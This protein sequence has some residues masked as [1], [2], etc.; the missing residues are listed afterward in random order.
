MMEWLGFRYHVVFL[1]VIQVFLLPTTAS[2]RRLSFW[3]C[4]FCLVFVL[5]PSTAALVTL[6]ERADL[7][8][9]GCHA[10]GIS[11][12]TLSHRQC[13]VAQAHVWSLWHRRRVSSPGCWEV[14]DGKEVA[15]GR[16]T[17]TAR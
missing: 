1:E 13:P 10:H 14:M 7:L 12:H 15:G 17:L 5:L 16:R 4:F 3:H 8:K 11:E 6:P 9:A 2:K